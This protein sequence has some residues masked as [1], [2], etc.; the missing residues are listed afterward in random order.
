M[1]PRI[2]PLILI[3]ALLLTAFGTLSGCNLFDPLDS[4]SGDAQL[5]SAAR[6]FFDQGDFAQAAEM[7]AKLSGDKADDVNADSAFRILDENGA[8]MGQFMIAFGTGQGSMGTGFTKLA[9]ALISSNGPAGKAKRLAI[10][11]AFQK[12]DLIQDPATRGMV[13]FATAAAMVAEI[14][15]EGA[16]PTGLVPNDIANIA[17]ICIDATPPGCAGNAA[18]QGNLTKFVT[19]TSLARLPASGTTSMSDDSPSFYVM[20]AALSEIDF[21]FTNEIKVGGR[22]G[23][24]LLTFL[25]MLNDIFRLG[26]ETD[27]ANASCARQ[28]LLAQGIGSS[29]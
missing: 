28:S 5:L 13:R 18:C 29:K 15:A 23:G 22:L 2:F 20:N 27:P 14:L 11:T 1:K 9:D 3:P 6:A 24:G 21:A 12:T 16:S 26:L 8:S 4:P 7:Y 19:G 25:G 17:A 10:L